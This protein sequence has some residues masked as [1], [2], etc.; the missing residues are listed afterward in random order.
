MQRVQQA[1]SETARPS[2]PGRSRHVADD[3]DV[4]RWLDLQQLE[5]LARNPVLDLG[6]L[7]NLL[8][9]RVVDTNRL[10]EQLAM[11]LHRDINIFIDRGAED[12]PIVAIVKS[13]QIRAAAGKADA[14]RR[15]RHDDV[16]T[17]RRLAPRVNCARGCTSCD[18]GLPDD[19]SNPANSRSVAASSSRLNGRLARSAMSNRVHD[20]SAKLSTQRSAKC[21][22]STADPPVDRYSP[23]LPSCGSP[24]GERFTHR[25]SRSSRCTRPVNRFSASSSFSARTKSGL[26]SEV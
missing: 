20:P 18:H 4:D 25:R 9:L 8:G 22:P 19:F 10:E 11:P 5:A 2:E 7:V 23:R 21:R 1:D 26:S 24:F 3:A 14:Q 12:S 16:V 15:P 6:Y 17:K 13:R